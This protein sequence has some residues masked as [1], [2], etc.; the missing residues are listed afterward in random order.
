MPVLAGG[1]LVQACDWEAARPE[2]LGLDGARLEA[3]SDDLAARKTKAFLV[4]RHGR[5]AYE[6]YAPGHGPHVRHMT[7]SL[8]KSVVSGMALLLALGDGRLSLDEPASN[9]IPAWQADP[10][11]SRITIRQLAT[12]T[13][14]LEDAETPGKGHFDQ[15]GWKEAFWR[16]APD[17]FG[18]ALSRAPVLF[19]PGTRFAYSNPGCAALAYS[20]TAALQGSPYPDLH[21][22]LHERL[23]QPLGLADEDWSIGYG[24]AYEADGLRLYATWGGGEYTARAAACLGQ[25]MLEQGRWRGRQLADPEW[26]QRMVT[27][28]GE[29]LPPRSA[30]EPWPAPGLCWWSNADSAMAWLPRD[31][32]IGAGAQH[33]ALL[34]VP[35]LNLVAVRNGS[36]L[37]EPHPDEVNQGFW[38]ALERCLLSPL[39]EAVRD[40]RQAPAP[41]YSPSSI[42]RRVSFAPASKIVRQAWH[43]DNWPTTWAA[44]GEQITSYGD[45]WG[46]LPEDGASVRVERKLS[47]GF[48]RIAGSA[49]DL[50][51]ENIRSATGERVGD[52]PRGPKS[53]G[54]VMVDGVLYMWVRNMHTAVSPGGSSCLAW[55]EDGARTWEWGF[56][57]E[58]SF[59]CPC[60]L[61]YGRNYAGAR[62]GFVYTYS[63]DGPSAYESYDHLVLARA[64]RERLRERQAWEFFAGL[65]PAGQPLWRPDIAERKPVFTYA[66]NCQRPDAVFHPGLRRYLLALGYNHF[67][68]WG[69]FDAPEPW[70]PWAV[71]FHTYNWGLGNTHGY[72]LPAKW[73]GPVQEGP[74]LTGRGPGETG[75][76]QMYLAF[77]GRTYDGVVYD[78]FCLREMTLATVWPPP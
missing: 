52:G 1:K 31:A 39:L 29:P 67:G 2:S 51:A 60:F 19:E 73:I 36:L 46:F 38:G 70:G 49:G 69:I 55:S 33:Q 35:S 14:G 57:L 16:R 23:M 56:R 59:G 64:P 77:S 58:E 40:R 17:P 27:Y 8:A 66:G 71:A 41:P 45:G 20:V 74:E 53:S 5:I 37:E 75:R 11:L 48:A 43:S 65:D 15:G 47:L 76:G 78:S 18:I 68:G 7:A 6:W 72:R 28:A 42:I 34:V 61:S 22:L 9:Y 26:V 12:H 44:D 50:R 63:P 25:L 54:M 30:G 4:L 24:R 10:V 32:F 62:D 3:L 21:S 13:S